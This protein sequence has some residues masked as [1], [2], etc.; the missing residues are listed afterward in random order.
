M[1]TPYIEKRGGINIQLMALTAFWHRRICEAIAVFCL[2]IIGLYLW[3][4]LSGIA[5]GDEF[6]VS[7]LAAGISVGAVILAGLS[8]FVVPESYRTVTAYAAYWILLYAIG[9]LTLTTGSTNSPFIATWMIAAM[10]AGIFGRLTLTILFV[11]LNVYVG[12]VAFQGDVSKSMVLSIVLAGE[13]PLLVSYI[14]WH[15]KSNT[16]KTKDRA[17]YDLANE[18]D[19]VSNKAEVVIGAISDGVI[20]I[21][22]HGEIEL[23]NPAAQQ[24]CGWGHQDALK[25]DYKSVLHLLTKNGSELEKSVDPVFSVLTTNQPIR[26]NDL[27]LQ[28]SSGKKIII[29]IVVSPIGRIGSGAIIVFRDV[30]KELEEEHAQAEFIS[31]ASHE[32][33]TPVASIEGYLGLALNPATATIDAKARDFITKAHE[34]AQHLGRLFQDLLDVTKADDGRISNNPKVIDVVQFTDDII[35]GLRQKA[36]EKNLKI[37]YKAKHEDDDPGGTR[38]VEPVFFVDVD[39][40]HLRE[41]LSNLIE[42]AIKYTP[43]GEV[44]IDVRGDD[45]HVV[46]S[47]ADSGIGIPAEDIPHLFQKFY[48]VDNTDTREIG[49]TGLGLYLCRKLV[50]TMGGRIW[51]DSE[52]KKGSTF[53]V[54]LKRIS[55]AEATRLIEALAEDAITPI[56]TNEA[57]GDTIGGPSVQ[58]KNQ[59]LSRPIITTK[60]RT[61]AT[62]PAVS[63]AAN[64]AA[65]KSFQPA[66]QNAGKAEPTT[67]DPIIGNST[68]TEQAEPL[69]PHSGMVLPPKLQALQPV[70]KT[71]VPKPAAPA[72]MTVVQPAPVSAPTPAPVATPTAASAR[73]QIPTITRAVPVA[74]PTERLPSDMQTIEPVLQP[75]PQAPP[76]SAR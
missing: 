67:I 30:T 51:V 52:Y 59:A 48:R 50:E 58:Q 43:H 60:T 27:Q 25:L 28:T 66:I 71:A 19:Q 76:V 15:G 53:S 35:G 4:A 2:L 38:T 22:N 11:G 29:E 36:T 37:Y 41:V 69:R 3:T 34:S 75:K 23:I 45:E 31:T 8:Y 7:P 47:I 70:V 12:Y 5:S 32:M 42:N 56:R 65:A 10:F 72:T 44:V 46:V 21:N 61:I 40:D 57:L 54:E 14:L 1:L 62:M 33:R 24:I 16:D 55:H 6:F 13:L 73:N 39:A 17:Y 26:R 20:A 9:A 64:G 74:Q 63:S 68:A 49:G 18:L